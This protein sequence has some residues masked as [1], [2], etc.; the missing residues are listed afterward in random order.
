MVALFKVTCWALELNH[1][2]FNLFFATVS[3]L[4][5]L[6][7][8]RKTHALKTHITSSCPWATG[9]NIVYWLMPL[10]SVLSAFQRLSAYFFLCL[11]CKQFSK[12]YN[13]FIKKCQK[14]SKLKVNTPTNDKTRWLEKKWYRPRKWITTPGYPKMSRCKYYNNVR[15]IKVIYNQIF[16]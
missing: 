2:N 4:L 13:C 16:L 9:F 3:L 7:D 8:P 5:A 10:T 15:F 1:L 11:S 6:F 12:Y 14:I